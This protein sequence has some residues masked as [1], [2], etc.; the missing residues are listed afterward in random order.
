M[1]KIWY[2]CYG[3]NLLDAR[4]NC[5]IEGGQPEGATRVY[6]GCRD[7]TLP[8]KSE[9]VE[10]HHELY[11]A[12]SATTWNGGGVCFIKPEEDPET[13]SFGKRYLITRDQFVELVKQEIDFKGSLDLDFDKAKA[14]GGLLFKEE[15]WYGQL[16]YLGE[17]EGCPIFTFTNARY[18]KDEINPPDNAYLST[19]IKGLKKSYGFSN[20]SIEQYLSQLKGVKG[21]HV[22]GKLKALIESL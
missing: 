21:S 6:D 4:F 5:Y 2:A 12:K 18:L 13:T 3:S 22:Q 20:R 14:E 19:F 9:P 15:A 16:L 1:D 8:E 11:F 7:K 10:M 17:K